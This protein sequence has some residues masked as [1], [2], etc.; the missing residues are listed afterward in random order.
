MHCYNKIY[1]FNVNFRL[2]KTIYVHLLVCYLNYKM[3]GATLKIADYDF[4]IDSESKG[5]VARFVNEINLCGYPHVNMEVKREET[6]FE[7]RYCLS[8][9]NGEINQ[10][11][12]HSNTSANEHR[13]DTH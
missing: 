12:T 5:T 6:Y 11:D 8:E 2:L 10:Q 7:Q 9:G 1:S 4:M 3:H 13:Q